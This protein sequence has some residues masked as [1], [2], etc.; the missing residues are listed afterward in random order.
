MTATADYIGT[1]I[2]TPRN[3]ARNS[4]FF[5]RL[6]RLFLHLLIAPFVVQAVAEHLL[7]SLQV[8]FP[9][10]LVLAGSAGHLQGVEHLMNQA[11]PGMHDLS[12]DSMVHLLLPGPVV[13]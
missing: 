10:P 8:L 11:V 5:S 13:L 9:V 4:H 12:P 2:A 7:V 3:N 6:V 1:P